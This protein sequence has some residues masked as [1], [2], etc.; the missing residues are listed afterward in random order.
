MLGLN[1][2][3]RSTAPISSATPVRRPIRIWSAAGST[4]RSH[5]RRP[6]NLRAPTSCSP[7][8]RP[9]PGRPLR[10]RVGL[11]RR[12]HLDGRRRARRRPQGHDLDR[13][14]GPFIAVATPVLGREV[15]HRRHRQLVALARV[16]AVDGRRQ[17]SPP[18]AAASLRQFVQGDVEPV[19]I[20]G[21]RPRSHQIGLPRGGEYPR[22]RQNAGARRDHDRGHP[23]FVGQRARVQRPGATE[24]DERKVAR[25]DAANDGHGADGLDHRC[26][27]HR[28]HALGSDAGSGQARRAPRWRRADRLRETRC[29]RRC[30]RRQGRRRSP[31]AVAP[32]RP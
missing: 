8:R 5:P 18:P 31:S 16:P 32:P 30:G 2:A 11:T 23:E 29:R 28:D 6:A 4:I 14:V 10:R 1:A 25:V 27:D 22:G 21:R 15:A 7:A 13:R 17:R 26:V 9:Q 20:P 12:Q 24:G 19:E 3:R